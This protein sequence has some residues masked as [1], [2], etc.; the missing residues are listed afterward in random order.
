MSRIVVAINYERLKW[1]RCCAVWIGW[2][3]HCKWLSGDFDKPR[4]LVLLLK[5]RSHK[6][7]WLI[8]QKRWASKKSFFFFRYGC[9]VVYYIIF[10]WS[11][12]TQFR[13]KQLMWQKKGC[14]RTWNFIMRS[15]QKI[16]DQKERKNDC[17]CSAQKIVFIF[18]LIHCILNLLNRISIG[19]TV[20][21]K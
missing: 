13:V 7:C 11:Q 9:C 10:W 14:V 5:K 6:N 8:H 19:K 20:R 1:D 21:L 2:N 15:P 4:A 3:R 18:P 17:C 16:R 12:A